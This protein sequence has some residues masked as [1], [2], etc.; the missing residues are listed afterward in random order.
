MDTPLIDW[1]SQESYLF[2]NPRADDPFKKIPPLKSHIFIP[3]S[4][5]TT[6]PRLV[7]LSKEAF[8]VSARAVNEA[9]DSQKD[10][11]WVNILPYYHVGGLST[12]ARAHLSHASHY[13]L[14]SRWD[15]AL[16]TSTLVDKKATLTSLVPTQLYDLVKSNIK[17]P[18]SLR[19]V[20][21]GGDYLSDLIKEKAIA[22]G[23]S[24]V[25]TYGMSET[26]SQI[27]LEPLNSSCL[28]ILSH[29]ELSTDLKG[30]LCIKSEA[31]LT[32]YGVENLGKIDLFDPK[33]NGVFIAED[34]VE[35]QN[36]QL[37]VL[38][39][40]T[41][42]VKILGEGVSLSKLEGLMQECLKTKECLI[43]CIEDDRAGVKLKLICAG[44]NF[45]EIEKGLAQFNKKVLPYEKVHLW[46]LVD[47][48]PRT[49]LGK[50]I[51]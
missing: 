25:R 29:M 12:L 10:D 22:L 35:I 20:F 24:V 37:K 34:F 39:R 41:H 2:G 18:S 9:I 26:C 49:F 31:L 6:K 50:L 44:V 40:A 48:L 16:F 28:K 33:N 36:D 32:A 27:A 30:R 8:L 46:E 42:F 17:A 21:V 19:R 15:P 5:T 13:T 1:Q 51:K 47:K 45:K 11:V 3:T 38:G 23:W 14:S 7:A 4:G 43:K